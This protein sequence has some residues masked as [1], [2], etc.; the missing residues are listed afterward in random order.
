MRLTARQ[1]LR[2]EIDALVAQ[3]YDLTEDEFTHIL[4]TF[5]WSVSLA[6]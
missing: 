4:S 2:A 5:P 6:A 3:L 1:T